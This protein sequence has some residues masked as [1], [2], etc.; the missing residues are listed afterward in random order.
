MPTPDIEESAAGLNLQLPQIPIAG[1]K[2]KKPTGP[3]SGAQHRDQDTLQAIQAWQAA[4][5]PE[6]AATMLK[7]L[8]PVFDR[9]IRQFVPGEISPTLRAHAKHIALEQLPQYDVQKA[10]PE[11]FLRPHLQRLQR[12]QVQQNNIISVPERVLMERQA[13]AR[14]ETELEDQY[15][16]SPSTLQLAD[17]LGV[18]VKRIKYIR[19]AQLP[20]SESQSI[21]YGEDGEPQEQAVEQEQTRAA[22]HFVYDS[23]D[24]ERDRRILEWSLGLHGHK[25]QT[26]AAIANRLHITPSAVSQRAQ[27]IQQQVDEIEQAG[28][29]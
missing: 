29:F 13:L 7:Q 16:V 19:Q 25:P 10:S 21:M 8:R 23:L 3:F 27:K 9:A 2:L 6:L 15:G 1:L 28:L 22:A 18:P 4:P 5:T 17:Y 12:L 20:R 26:V 11:T 14:A 24:D